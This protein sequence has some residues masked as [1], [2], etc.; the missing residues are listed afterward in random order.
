MAAILLSALVGCGSSANGP[1][2]PTTTEQSPT[3][4]TAAGATSTVASTASSVAPT[5][6]RVVLAPDGLGPAKFGQPSDTVISLLTEVLGPPAVRQGFATGVSWGAEDGT[7]L[8]AFFTFPE[9]GGVSHFT[10]WSLSGDGPLEGV[11]LATPDGITLGT[12]VADLLAV[13]PDAVVDADWLPQC[14]DS[15]WLPNQFDF[16]DGVRG[17]AGPLADQSDAVMNMALAA[18]AAHGHPIDREQC[19]D[20]ACWAVVAD[21]QRSVGLPDSGLFDRATWLALG[22]PLPADPTAVFHYLEAGTG[23]VYC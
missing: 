10:G 3:C 19:G 17:I 16:G 6:Q 22:L 21:Y 11:E 9:A 7:R 15:W 2:N 23:I 1:E 12:S 20:P 13:H 8:T 14:G 4:T 5:G 18:L